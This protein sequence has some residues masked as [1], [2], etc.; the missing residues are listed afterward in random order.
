MAKLPERLTIRRHITRL[1]S[2][3]GRLSDFQDSLNDLVYQH[4][5]YCL[6]IE[7]SY[8]YDEHTIEIYGERLENDEEY[9]LRLDALN[10]QKERLRQ[11]KKTKLEKERLEYERLKKKFG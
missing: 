8:D 1:Y 3:D 7:T 4:R 11:E 10:E 6:S 2:I 5:E 9:Q